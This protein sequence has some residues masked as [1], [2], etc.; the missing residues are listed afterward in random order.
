MSGK[1][2]YTRWQNI[3]I[4]QFGFANNL[5]MGLSMAVL[6]F[7]INFV[8]GEETALNELQKIA[9]WLGCSLSVLSVGLGLRVALSRLEDFR[10]TAR[11]ARKRE[12][13]VQEGI[14]EDRNRSKK[15]GRRSWNG[16]KGQLLCFLGGTLSF[17]L[18][19]LISLGNKIT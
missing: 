8:N 12:R 18:L 10:L 13:N 14:E 11:I 2:S 9:F 16:F 1:D 6:G 3:R 17:L 7:A 19:I 5:I 4:T 15:L